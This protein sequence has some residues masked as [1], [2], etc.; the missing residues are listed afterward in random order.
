[1][2]DDRCV[3]R[4]SSLHIISGCISLHPVQ[5]WAGQHWPGTGT[6]STLVPGG[7]EGEGQESEMSFVGGRGG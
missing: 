5:L 4:C 3:C 2:D 7:Q 1:M 6:D